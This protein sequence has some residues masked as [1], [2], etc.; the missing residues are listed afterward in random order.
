MP[1][2]RSTPQVA[3]SSQCTTTNT[4]PAKLTSSGRAQ[5]VE[6][7]QPARALQQSA[8]GR[9]PQE[10]GQLERARNRRV[11]GR[12]VGHE[13][14]CVG[15]DAQLTQVRHRLVRPRGK[16]PR[17]SLDTVAKLAGRQRPQVPHSRRGQCATDG[18]HAVALEVHHEVVFAGLAGA[19]DVEAERAGPGHQSNRETRLVAIDGGANDAS[20]C[21][22]GLQD[23][24]DDRVALLAD[25]GYVLA[26]RDRQRGDPG[27][28]LG[29]AGRFDDEIQWQRDEDVGVA[30]GDE[31]PALVC[32]ECVAGG[33]AARDAILGDAGAYRR[34][35]D[36]LEIG[37]GRGRNP[38]VAGT[39]AT[40][41][42]R[43]AEL[44]YAHQS[45]AQGRV[46]ASREQ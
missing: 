28:R 8:L 29:R 4:P 17:T 16:D 42:E 31:L 39:G 26:S 34:T 5:A 12:R 18:S 40:E 10:V 24:A 14:G 23:R 2:P 15:N 9:G 36:A 37:I 27:R 3:G 20:R 19:D 45:G 7:V 33:L 6:R 44:A 1:L 43:R 21:R 22:A 25:H 38:Q 11:Q 30:G 13:L 35:Y 41:E 46:V 32:G